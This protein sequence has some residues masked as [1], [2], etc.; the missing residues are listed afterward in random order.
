MDLFTALVKFAA[1]MLVAGAVFLVIGSFIAA[2]PWASW[3]V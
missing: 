2:L 3:H 1:I